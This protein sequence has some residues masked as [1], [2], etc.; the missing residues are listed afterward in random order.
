L[1]Y[2]ACYSARMGREKEK[3]REIRLEQ[4]LIIMEVKAPE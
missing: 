1:S 3:K 2:R 4:L